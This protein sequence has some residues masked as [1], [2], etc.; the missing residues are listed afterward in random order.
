MAGVAPGWEGADC[1]SLHRFRIF[2]G[3]FYSRID[4]ARLDFTLVTPGAVRVEK[5]LARFK[6]RYAFD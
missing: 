5:F 3:I 1:G 2:C 4:N 6:N